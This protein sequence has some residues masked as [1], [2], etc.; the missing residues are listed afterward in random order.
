MIY[1]QVVILKLLLKQQEIDTNAHLDF[2][3]I[4]DV[5]NVNNF[6]TTNTNT[7]TLTI[8]TTTKY[9]SDVSQLPTAIGGFHLLEDNTSY[10]ICGQITL[11]NG[12][13]YGLIFQQV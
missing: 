8:A 13:Q 1:Y 4:F 10:I 6:N 12:I 5:R 11:T 9:I 2:D 3:N 7:T